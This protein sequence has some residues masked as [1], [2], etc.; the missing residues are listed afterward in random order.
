MRV[1]VVDL[2]LFSLDLLPI[3]SVYLLK[4]G[5]LKFLVGGSGNVKSYFSSYFIF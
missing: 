3:S 4:V 1:V 2:D 5:G